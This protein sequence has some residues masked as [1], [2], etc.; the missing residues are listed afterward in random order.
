MTFGNNCK[1]DTQTPE[2]HHHAAKLHLLLPPLVCIDDSES[3]S[4]MDNATDKEDE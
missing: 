4:D 1:Y 3:D 2:K